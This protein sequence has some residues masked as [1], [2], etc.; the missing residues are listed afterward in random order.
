MRRHGF[1]TV[2]RGIKE[3]VFHAV[4]AIKNARLQ[5]TSMLLRQTLDSSRQ[6]G[7]EDVYLGEPLH[8][9]EGL[10]EQQTKDGQNT[11]QGAIMRPWGLWVHEVKSLPIYTSKV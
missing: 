7:K 11:S 8:A 4:Y 5:T 2:G 10:T 9:L 6:G 3:A 1:T